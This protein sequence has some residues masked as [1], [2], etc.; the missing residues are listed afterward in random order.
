MNSYRIALNFEDGVTRFVDCGA[1]EKVLD[2]A[3]RNRINLP[4]DCSDGVC[5]TCKC[6]AES[7]TYDMGDDYIDEALTGDEA[8]EGLVLTCQ[9]VPQSD[10]VIAVP[11]PSTACK[12]GT[13]KFG[14]KVEAV[15]PFGD[16]AYELALDVK[17]APVFLPGQYVNI[18][19][20]GSE[21]HRS[22]S[23]S[24]ASG[25][26]RMTF[27]I[28]NVPGGLM[29]SWLA[30]AAPGADL[31]MTGPLGSFYLRAV[32]RPLLFLAGGTGL[33]PFLSML[34]ELARQGTSQ[35]VHMI[36]GVTRDQD[37]VQVERLQDYALRVPGF[38]FTTCVADPATTHERQGYVTQ[39]MPAQALHNGNVDV[40]LCGPPPMVDAVQKHFKTEGITPAS[41]H[42]EKFTANQP[43]A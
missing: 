18:G 19:V 4:M 22:Y 7:G 28:K 31:E 8:A 34:E 11:V 29:S 12:T 10:C 25:A 33:A 6:R 17:D 38:T 43:A 36:Y 23:F 35:P 2:A 30:A 13:S 32:T 16:A 41:F 40:Y 27:L 24:S 14:A 37:L 9:M 39:H 15:T 21:Q 1:N 42:Y 20:P 3:F 26:G 5:G